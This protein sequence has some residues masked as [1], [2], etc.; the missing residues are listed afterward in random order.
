MGIKGTEFVVETTPDGP[1]TLSVLD[2][3]VEVRPAVGEPVL[4]A[5]GTKVT[6]DPARVPVGQDL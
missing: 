5:A 6:F 2:G 3:S 1:T 4:A